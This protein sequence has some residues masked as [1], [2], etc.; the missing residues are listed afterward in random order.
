MT[1]VDRE[2]AFA[3]VFDECLSRIQAGEATLE[4]C[5]SAYP[6]L[7]DRLAPLLETASDLHAHL[8]PEGP[9][10]QFVATS[11]IRLA[12]RLQ[13]EA[14]R[15]RLGRE[16]AERRPQPRRQRLGLRPIYALASALVVLLICVSGAGV[17][18]AS[19]GALPGDPLYGVK[20]GV[21][22][23]RLVLSL[24]DQG[25][26]ELLTQFAAR[27]LS[28][29]Q[30]LL[31]GGRQEDLPW[32]MLA[33][34]DVLGRLA[35]EVKQIAA[36]GQVQDEALL[37]Q[38]RDQLSAQVDILQEVIAL[39]PAPDAESVVLALD[40]S[41]AFVSGLEQGRE[42]VMALELPSPQF[43]QVALATAVP[44]G[45]P[46]PSEAPTRTVAASST[47]ESAAGTPAP[48]ETSSPTSTPAGTTQP[49]VPPPAAPS[50]ASPNHTAN[51]PSS[52]IF[53]WIDVAGETRYELKHAD[54][55]SINSA[56]PANSVS[57][58]VMGLSPN[59][60]ASVQIRACKEGS[61]SNWSPVASAYTSANTPSGLSGSPSC[62][63]ILWNWNANGN[64]PD[65]LYFVQT[66]AYS[67]QW[68]IGASWLQ[69]GVT[70]GTIV[71]QV[72]ARNGDGDQTAFSPTGTVTGSCSRPDLTATA[73][74][75]PGTATKDALVSFTYSI[76]NIGPVIAQ[77]KY[78]GG[79]VTRLYV[80]GVR[81]PNDG[82]QT[83]SRDT[84]PPGL[85]AGASDTN[86]FQWKA[87][88]GTHQVHVRTDD[89]N[90]VDESD[91][92]N[93][94]TGL[95]SITVVCPTPTP[96]VNPSPTSSANKPDLVVSQLSTSGPPIVGQSVQVYA[97]VKN[98]GP[99]YSTAYFLTRLRRNGTVVQP[100]MENT[101]GLPPGGTETYAWNWTPASPG[102]VTLDACTDFDFA[103]DESN[104]G[105]NCRTLVVSVGAG[106]T[107]T[108]PPPTST[109][110]P[111]PTPVVHSS[112]SVIDIGLN[113][114]FDLD[115]GFATLGTAADLYYETTPLTLRDLPG[116][117]WQ[118]RGGGSGKPG[119]TLSVY[120]LPRKAPPPL[121]W[122]MND[123]LM[124]V[125]GSSSV[126]Y[127]GCV[128]ANLGSNPIDV[129]SLSEGT[130]I[131]VLTSQDRYS[132]FVIEDLFGNPPIITISYTTW[133]Y[134]SGG[135]TPEP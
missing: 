121:L 108:T 117:S 119:P 1:M 89:D 29:A 97:T 41:Q 21:E 130:W 76:Q 32:A 30:G 49:A 107:A 44:S 73:Y 112:G 24:S 16:Q 26:A 38:I 48:L 39:L 20:R 7:A 91:E 81:V 40:S 104:E 132:E 88:C 105:N 111:T 5:L 68:M 53:A 13:V 15:E 83:G 90:H 86:G 54:G 63:G 46:L 74:S 70:S 66:N 103:V 3:Q 22:E 93:N 56:V 126:G 14:K 61:C 37:A 34:L 2:A 135:G 33:Y 59:T 77:G 115:E 75:W 131:C 123:A 69:S 27:R 127:S 110:I 28:E 125:V 78:W 87:T 96:T 106:P 80:D 100:I 58:P 95:Y 60:R 17:F 116:V 102:T 36:S 19:A 113:T 45:T 65:T 114:G 35:T 10:R 12:N 82:I 11:G 94:T 18:S 25:D 67:S 6:E 4:E 71:G 101:T 62:S 109:P 23:V 42:A 43:T 92:S 47:T 72:K 8:S 134:P 124:A 57:Y 55:R 128:A 84:S 79:F 133:E 52:V 31:Q 98:Q 120:A 85:A 129:Y 64:P 122:P 99:A 50:W 118:V 9:T 51:T